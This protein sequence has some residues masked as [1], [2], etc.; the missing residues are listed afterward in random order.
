MP[1]SPD[2]VPVQRKPPAKR[3]KPLDWLSGRT[4]ELLT[5]VGNGST[6]PVVGDWND[7]DRP[8]IF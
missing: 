3:R 6:T 2:T 5:E 4:G 1:A 7:K 8:E